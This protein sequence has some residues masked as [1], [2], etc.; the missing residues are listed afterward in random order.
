[1]PIGT[2][3][4]GWK[5]YAAM[6]VVGQV[7]ERQWCD[8]SQY[9]A[10]ADVK[11][12]EIDKRQAAIERACQEERDCADVNDRGAI[13]APQ[14][15]E[16]RTRTCLC[17]F[18]LPMNVLLALTGCSSSIATVPRQ[19]KAAVDQVGPAATGAE[20]LANVSAELKA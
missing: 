8:A 11:Q 19:P 14:T 7:L 16:S 6:F 13:L 18:L 2:A 12:T 20:C 5:G 1:M 10:D 17:R 15:L 4:R 9:P 3:L